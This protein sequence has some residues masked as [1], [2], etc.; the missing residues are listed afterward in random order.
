ME[1]GIYNWNNYKMKWTTNL[2]E[3][4]NNFKDIP[5]IEGNS[6]SWNYTNNLRT[7]QTRI[8]NSI[9]HPM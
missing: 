8:Q 5:Y 7:P 6:D 3:R 4:K 1:K 2:L 9:E